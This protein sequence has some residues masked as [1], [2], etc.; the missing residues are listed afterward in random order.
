MGAHKVTIPLL[1]GGVFSF[2]PK[3]E[4]GERGLSLGHIAAILI[5]LNGRYKGATP[6]FTNKELI[7]IVWH[8]VYKRIPHEIQDDSEGGT[9]TVNPLKPKQQAFVDHYLTCG[10]NGAKA[11]R[12]AGY[13]PKRAKQTAYD[14]LHDRKRY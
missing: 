1:D 13:S 7:R 11:A 2:V 10:F 9:V 3:K 4:K 5:C 12:L 14:L 6:R 8:L